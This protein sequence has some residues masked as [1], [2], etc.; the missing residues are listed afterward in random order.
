MGLQ[1]GLKMCLNGTRGVIMKYES[2]TLLD[3]LQMLGIFLASLA[4]LA[5]ITFITC[6]RS[7]KHGQVFSDSLSQDS[8]YILENPPDYNFILE[9]DMKDLPSYLEAIQNQNHIAC[10]NTFICTL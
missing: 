3:W 10:K 1:T 6:R 7:K 9:D 8:K 4:A 5:L 2:S